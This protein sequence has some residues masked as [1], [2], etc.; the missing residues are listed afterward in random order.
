M[1]FNYSTVTWFATNFAK[2]HKNDKKTLMIKLLIYE[3]NK[4]YL[5]LTEM[6]ILV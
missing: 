2:S 6:Y 3:S 5:N 4:K 1:S